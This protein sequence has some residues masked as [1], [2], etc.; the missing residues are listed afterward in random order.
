[1]ALLSNNINDYYFV[2]QGKTTIPHVDDAEELQI[3]DVSPS[4]YHNPLVCVASFKTKILNQSF[5]DK[6]LI[7]QHID[8]QICGLPEPLLFPHTK[9]AS[10]T[11][12]KRL[13]HR[14][15]LSSLW[16][17]L[18]HLRIHHLSA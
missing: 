7:Y 17:K 9:I 6:L 2:S 15:D 13:L 16:E 11:L 12:N 10:F 14:S 4:P 1:M 3:T 18:R 5:V 8:F